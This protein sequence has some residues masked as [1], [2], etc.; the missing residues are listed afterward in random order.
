MVAEQLSSVAQIRKALEWLEARGV[1]GII[2][3]YSRR[4]GLPFVYLDSIEQ[5]RS[6]FPG[7]TA[8][9]KRDGIRITYRLR[10]DGIDF[11]AYEW[12]SEETPDPSEVSL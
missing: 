8:T 10:H 12:I 3:V 11:S 7:Q 6:L 2:G 1:E 5:M 4:D 9:K